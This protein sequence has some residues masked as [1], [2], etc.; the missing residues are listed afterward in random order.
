MVCAS[1]NEA[2]PLP[3]SKVS[4]MYT[5]SGMLLETS[6]GTNKSKLALIAICG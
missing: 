5:L 3:I 6:A 2:C 4:V 1:Q